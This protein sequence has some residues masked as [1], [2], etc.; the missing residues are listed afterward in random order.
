MHTSPIA[1]ALSEL[2]VGNAVSYRN[3]VMLPLVPREPGGAAAPDYA[4]LDEAIAA[5]DVEITEVSEQGSVPDLRLVNRGARPVLV[6]DGEELVGAK[7]NRIV[8]LTILVPARSELTIPVSCVEAGRWRS[9]SRAFSAAPRAQYATGRAKRMAQV[10][11]SMRT[12]RMYRSDQA[13]VWSDISL[14]AARLQSSSPTGAMEA[15]FVDHAAFMDACVAALGPVADQIG[16]VFAVDG[17]VTGVDLFDSCATLQKLLP[18]L[19]R[20]AAIEA[21][22]AGAGGDP[23]P[24]PPPVRRICEQFL[25]AVGV[26][27][28]YSAAA[29]GLGE[30]WR[31]TAPGIAGSGL[32]VDGR[33]VHISALPL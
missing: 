30:D 16:A 21:I 27:P 10:T 20:S 26:A 18:K 25:A 28:T 11:E 6:L 24:E 7:Q 19:V 14:K 29:V 23:L 2:V 4:V 22:D 32:V 15:M 8:N 13:E 5:K 17:R 12:S 1:Q 31:L 33:M 3:L 9:R